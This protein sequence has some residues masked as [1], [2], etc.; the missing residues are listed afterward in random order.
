MT[1]ALLTKRPTPAKAAARQEI[2]SALLE[3]AAEFPDAAWTQGVL[4]RNAD[5]QE[6]HYNNPNAVAYCALGRLHRIMEQAGRAD[7][8]LQ[9]RAAVDQAL[10]ARS[11][12]E[13]IPWNDAPERTPEEV[14]ELFQ[15]AA[16]S[17][18]AAAAQNLLPGRRRQ[19]RY[20]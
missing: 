10:K 12:Q 16:K 20:R 7:L 9:L 19:S 6:V 11:P 5:G 8:A 18:R 14:R 2:Q 13:L 17:L 1:A 4:A 15:A 3:Q